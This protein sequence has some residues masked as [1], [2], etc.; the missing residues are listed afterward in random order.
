M[1]AETAGRVR[2]G[3]LGPLAVWRDGEP[4]GLGGERQRSLL[5]LLLIR[6]NELVSVEVLVDALFG[7]APSDGAVHAVRVAVSRLRRLLENGDEHPVLETRPG[8][9]VLA[10]EPERLDAARFE[11]LLSDGR[12]LLSA[13]DPASSAAR[14]R[15]ALSLWRGA[16]LADLPVIEHL[17]AEM[18]RLEE[19]R[20]AALIERVDADLALGGGGELIAELEPLIAANPLQERLRGQLMLAL[21]RAGR[22][23]DALAVYRH[24]S[25]LLRD[26]LGLEP[27][28]ALKQLERSIL[29]QDPALDLVRAASV[30]AT[31]GS[32]PVP[33]TAFL[34]REQELGELTPQPMLALY[35]NE[36][37]ADALSAYQDARRHLIDELGIEP[38]VDLQALQTAILAQDPELA[39]P[40]LSDSGPRPVLGPTGTSVRRAGGR[41]AALPERSVRIIGRERELD[42]L[43]RLLAD[44][45]VALLTL[46]GTGGI[47]KTTLGVE[48][49]RAA[50]ATFADGVVMVRLASIA[51]EQQVMT[52]IARVL[53]IE[54]SAHEPATDTIVRVLRRQHR[55]LLLDN[56]EH[57]L[58]VAPAIGG[59][60]AECPQLKV[61][62]TSRA[63]LRVAFERVYRVGSLSAPDAAEP[64]TVESLR[65]S[66]AGALFLERV[67]AFTPG[68]ALK[69]ADAGTIID[70]CRYLGGIP[71]ALELAAAR[72]AV[73]APATIIERLRCG[74]EPLGPARRDAPARQQTLN[75]TIEWSFELIEPSERALMA[76]LALFRAGFTP[77]SA[78][79]VGGDLMLSI[80]DALG[81]LL[82]HS[83]IE[84][85]T[86][87]YGT[88]FAMLEPVRAYALEL[89]RADPTHAV[90]LQRHAAYYASFAAAAQAGLEGAEQLDWLDRV[91]DEQANLRAVMQSAV[92]ESHVDVG[93]RIAWAL[94]R[95]W[96]IRDL[97]A[98]LADW[99]TTVLAHPPG[100]A[101]VRA[102]AMY[103]LGRT[104]AQIGR[105]DQAIP[106][107]RQSLAICERHPDARLM[108]LSESLLALCLRHDGRLEEAAI[109]RSRALDVVAGGADPITHAYVLM[110]VV[111]CVGADVDRD[112]RLRDERALMRRAIG[113]Y[114][115]AGDRFA[116]P[117]AKSNLGW[118]AWLAGDL[119]AARA[120]LEEAL[121]AVEGISVAGQEAV[122][123][124]NLGLV[125]LVEGSTAAARSNLSAA[126]AV[127]T[128]AG[129]V[130]ASREA[131]IG[132]AALA[133]SQGDGALSARLLAGARALHDGPLKRGEVLLLDRFF[134]ELHPEPAAGT[135]FGHPSLTA[136]ELAALLRAIARDT[137]SAE[138]TIETSSL[139]SPGRRGI[140]GLTDSQNV[141]V[142]RG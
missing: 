141:G 67:T 16:P 77:D 48:A 86:A 10:V 81:K 90:V 28:R 118:A 80:P 129:E 106:A 13:G 137:D 134:G 14:L 78:E 20:L 140:G 98:E 68:F 25:G 53:G 107:L 64:A 124:A 41:P 79:V 100:D 94:S 39:P 87:R 75:A 92:S 59:L 18:R 95:Y 2:F 102:Q 125:D 30:A 7:E 73:L 24:L 29:Q 3:V 22:Q 60:V 54:L 99:L 37:Q 93:L 17:Q 56:F 84:P 120:S 139:D 138:L 62:V 133:A 63:P 21:Y 57:V 76:R 104:A 101:S 122:I 88:R 117:Y 136:D 112:V 114:D 111:G 11:R 97:S 32:L 9:Y 46:T 33:A 66:P 40:A 12:G 49:A 69:P 131:M 61:L 128:L 108:A 123:R 27:G 113:L 52:E 89:L 105:R 50:R 85:V 55:L 8:G 116:L 119:M 142:T 110:N 34:G 135:W 5:A 1:A 31:A 44:P 82:D 47:G 121:T 126:V 74:S 65:R 6:A 42:E 70:L 51:S 23:T 71:L 38:G 58:G 19:L 26:E 91:D 45:G 35:R 115:S 15:D 103:T 4:V 109:H 36:R 72:A 132:L 127:L 96:Y 83:L 130:D 43:G